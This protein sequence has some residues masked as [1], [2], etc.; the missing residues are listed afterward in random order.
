MTVMFGSARIPTKQLER[1]CRRLSISLEAGIDARTALAREAERAPGAAARRHMVSIRDAIQRGDS[2]HDALQETGDYFP[3]LF[4]GI[5]HI[6]ERSGHLGEALGQLADH[7]DGRLRLR[8]QFLSSIAWPMTELGAAVVLIGFLIWILG[9]IG[10]SAGTTIDV[11]GLGLVG[12]RGL[13]IYCAFVAGVAIFVLSAVHAIRRGL[14]WVKPV[15]RIALKIP[16]IGKP[17]MTIALARL[18]WAMNLTFNAGM[19]VRQALRLSLENARNVHFTDQIQPID[20][21]VNQGQSLHEAFSQTGAFPTDFLDS[22]HTAEESGKLV[23]SM[24]RL[25]KQYQ[26]QAEASLHVLTTLAGFA[27]WAV[28]AAIIVVAI[29]RLFSFYVGMIEQYSKPG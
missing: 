26:E 16:G 3:E 24:G 27:V 22:L 29:F 18:A 4:R 12:N 2:L 21:A 10:H 9:I 13:A 1:L 25:S 11:L 19:D 5:V 6:G 8:R 14:A 20:E 15:Q 7:Y 28:I 17:L 23:E